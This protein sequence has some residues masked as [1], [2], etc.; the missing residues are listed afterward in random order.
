MQVQHAL[1]DVEYQGIPVKDF[2]KTMFQYKDKI[3]FTKL[4]ILHLFED[5]IKFYRT[6]EVWDL[7]SHLHVVIM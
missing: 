7:W 5:L 6:A 1:N 2:E 3:V 4:D